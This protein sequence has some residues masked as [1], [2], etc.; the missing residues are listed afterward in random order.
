MCPVTIKA[1]NLTNH[2]KIPINNQNNK[3]RAPAPLAAAVSRVAHATRGAMDVCQNVQST[4]QVRSLRRADQLIKF[5]S[6]MS[7]FIPFILPR[8][9][10]QHYLLFLIVM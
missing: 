9:T 8:E 7:S 1:V 2:Y 6:K 5:V 10:F 4:S 3:T